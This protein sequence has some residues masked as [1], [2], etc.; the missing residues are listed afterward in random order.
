MTSC[1]RSIVSLAVSFEFRLDANISGL[2][3]KLFARDTDT[4]KP[5]VV[6]ATNTILIYIRYLYCFNSISIDHLIDK[7]CD[8]YTLISPLFNQEVDT[9]SEVILNNHF[10]TYKLI[11]YEK[12]TEN[13]T[14]NANYNSYINGRQNIWFKAV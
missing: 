6:P 13:I 3:K 5:C 1:V 11:T 7:T 8:N 10:N 14:I 2:L 9:V 12:W 4:I